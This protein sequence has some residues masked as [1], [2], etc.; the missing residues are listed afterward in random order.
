MKP[1]QQSEMKIINE[2]RKNS[3]RNLNE[4]A[5]NAG[6]PVSTTYEKIKGYERGKIIKR[7]TSLIDFYNLGYLSRV[8]V[9]IKVKREL[10]EN[11]CNMLKD[12]PNINSV[13]RINRGYDYLIE[14]V[15]KDSNEM[16]D[17]LEDLSMQEGIV[18]K[19]LFEILSE[20]KKE[21]FILK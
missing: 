10:R 12:H 15:A 16:S 3:R 21:E 8:I 2:L 11:I 19:N 17:I 4:L 7:H 13:Y 14:L 9:A 20:I 1:L 6:L 18:E 5:I